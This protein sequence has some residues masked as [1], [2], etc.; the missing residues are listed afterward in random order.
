ME[1]APARV[2]VCCAGTHDSTSCSGNVSRRR[3]TL[4]NAVLLA[5][6][7]GAPFA[8]HSARECPDDEIE[9]QVSF[10]PGIAVIDETKPSRELQKTGAYGM[11]HQLGLTLAN[12][13]RTVAVRMH[14]QAHCPRPTVRVQLSVQP[15]VIELASELSGMSCLRDHVLEHE[16]QHAAIYNAAAA[17]AAV[18]LG[19]EMQ[20]QLSVPAGSRDAASLRALH[21]RVNGYWL[22]R[23]D[24]LLA[25]GNAE[26]EAIDA[27]EPR[28]AYLAC[29][30][31]IAYFV[32][33]AH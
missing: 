27:L 25:Q 23:L 14:E 1:S 24:A 29:G 9:V 21:A 8:A 10:T 30:V 11:V 19:R 17:R 12:L 6:F 18:Q 2:P 31:D 28:E 22:A 32:R 4:L 33:I 20:I 7:A 3:H 13:Q 16:R 15:L 26:Q 5:S